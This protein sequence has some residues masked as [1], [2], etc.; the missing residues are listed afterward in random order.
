MLV[1]AGSGVATYTY[2][3]VKSLLK[4]YPDH[5]FR[6]FYSSFRKPSEFYYL[7]ELEKCGAKI[8]RFPIPTRGIRFL[9]NTISVLPVEWLIGRIDVFHSSDYHRPPL[10]KSTHAI[11]T[12]HD[13]TWKIFPEY[14][15][16]DVIAA[17][18][19]KLRR[20]IRHNDTIMVDSQNTYDDLIKEYPM[21]DRSRIHV[22][23]L[24][25]DDRYR[26]NVPK[27]EVSK[28]M[29]SYKL[30]ANQKYLLYI[31]AI[32]PRK[33]VDRS[34]KVFSQL[35]QKKAYADYIF[36]IAGR[37]GWKNEHV[38]QQVKDLGLE[39]K[40]IFTGFVPDKDVPALYTGAQ[41][42]MYL[43]TYEGFGLPPLEAALCGT[44]SLIYKNSSIK[45]TFPAKYAF[46]E[47][48][49]E[50]KTLLKILSKKVTVTRS[51]FD[52]Y[53]WDAYAHNFMRLCSRT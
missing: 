12:I 51:D 3:F 50:L 21:V 43:S 35:I 46:A 38:F 4:N 44:P 47:E 16:S 17:H 37:A 45:E 30:L 10:S 23:Y 41:A 52:A 42:L 28:L 22:M 25:V 33:N 26:E 6:L 14:H 39:D 8:Y 53:N 15:T 40:V 9:W 34:I 48:G 18:H 27:K 29:K 7:N 32:E 31:G 24:G 1:Y 36:I 20:T 2:N 49:N 5:E 11:T 19:R 13:L